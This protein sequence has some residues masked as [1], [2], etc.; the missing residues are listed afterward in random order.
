MPAENFF[1]SN[2]FVYL[3]ERTDLPKY[4]RAEVL[5]R[6]NLD[7]RTGCISYQVV[8]ETLN[9]V[10]RTVGAGSERLAQFLEQIL[11]PL[12]QINPINPTP[13]L[14]RRGLR[15]QARYGFSFYDSLIVAAALEAGCT[16]LYSEDMQ[17]GQRIQG[18]T[19]R[20]PFAETR[21]V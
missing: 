6:E 9:V 7:N 10:G 17:H 3:F 16:T 8:Q 5:V 19:I 15:V 11:I 14:Y 18:L 12:W 2:V 20:N 4:S 13:A 1:D 21:A